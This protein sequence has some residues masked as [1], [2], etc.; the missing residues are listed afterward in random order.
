MGEIINS[1]GCKPAV[2]EPRLD[3]DNLFQHDLD[4]EKCGVASECGLR[5]YVE[6]HKKDFELIR[7]YLKANAEKDKE[8]E[9]RIKSLKELYR[10]RGDFLK[11]DCYY[12]GDA[13]IVFECPTNTKIISKNKK[14]IEVICASLGKVGQYYV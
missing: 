5:P 14:H 7:T 12:S 10:K 8:T 1:V 13:I 4:G 2:A 9:S 3:K 6:F 11:I